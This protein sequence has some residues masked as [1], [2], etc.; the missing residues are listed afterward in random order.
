MPKMAKK[1]VN[2]VAYV[3]LNQSTTAMPIVEQKVQQIPNYEDSGVKYQGKFKTQQTGDT[4]ELRGQRTRFYTIGSNSAGAGPHLSNRTNPNTKF[5]CTKIIIQVRNMS[6]FSWGFNQIHIAD[7][8]PAGSA[9]IKF[10]F[11]PVE[12]NG[13][14]VFDLSDSPR[15]FTGDRFDL[16][17][18][19]GFGAG[20]WMYIHLFGWEEQP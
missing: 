5:Y 13:V 10:Y 18:Q 16:W 15:E 7:V 6:T 1:K 2:P 17:H 4:Y 11:F 3:P 20:E 14:Y 9:S 8:S 12:A 19:F